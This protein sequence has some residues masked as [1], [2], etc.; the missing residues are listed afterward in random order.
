MIRKERNITTL[1]LFLIKSCWN[2]VRFRK[3]VL[4]RFNVK[5]TAGQAHAGNPG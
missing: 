3:I 1:P 2:S 5:M 4:T